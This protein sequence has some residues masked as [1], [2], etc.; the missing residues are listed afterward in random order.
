MLTLLGN[1]TEAAGVDRVDQARAWQKTVGNFAT[2]AIHLFFPHIPVTGCWIGESRYDFSPM[3][4]VIRNTLK[5]DPTASLIL[6]LRIDMP[7]WWI[8]GHPD[9][10]L[11][12]EDGT[13]SVKTSWGT[14]VKAPSLASALWRQDV[15][16]LLRS[17]VNHVGQ[18]DYAR[19]VVG[20][21]P[22]LFHGGEWFQEG[23]QYGKKADYS[24][25]MERAFRVWL[26]T[27][28]PDE[29]SPERVIPLAS[30]RDVGDIGHLRDPEKSRNVLDYYEFYHQ[31]IAEQ[32]IGYCRIFKEETAGR[33]ITG[34]YYGYS[35]VLSMLPGWLQRSGHLALKRVLESP[36]VD[37]IGSMLDNEYLEREGFGWSFG[38]LADSARLH[39]K[40]FVAEDEARTWLNRRYEQYLSYIPWSRTAEEEVNYLKRNFSC[41]MTHCEH[42]ELADLEGGWYDDQRIMDCVGRLA[43]I[44]GD[45]SWSRSPVTQIAL[46]IDETAYFYQ[47][48]AHDAAL[49][50]PLMIDSM[51]EYF[52]IGAPLDMYL[53]SDLTDGRVPLERYKLIVLLNPWHITDR[54]RDFIKT[55][56]QSDGRWILTYYAPGFIG[57]GTPACESIR[58]L[59]GIQVAMDAKPG[60]LQIKSKGKTYGTRNPVAPIFYA[61]DAHAE[62]LARQSN[63]D[64]PAVS[65]KRFDKWTSVYSAVPALPA[66]LLRRLAKDAGVH[67]YVETDD[68]I[69]ATDGFLAIHAG[70]AGAKDLRLP[71]ICNLYDPYDRRLDARR[72][73]GFSL[74]MKKGDT[75]LWMLGEMNCT[76]R[77]Q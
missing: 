7:D 48:E 16:H 47:D 51:P 71:K 42:E 59:I 31:Q 63:A 49:N 18:S 28:Y 73:Q 24:P 23:S 26:R 20:Y 41:A 3:D 37:Y 65:L 36:Y 64:R 43:R 58:D 4:T 2:E 11:L 29:A 77:Q 40:V 55:R 15:E 52:H 62:V 8:N 72:T 45:P 60:L 50:S 69:Y 14:Q 9:Q 76:K 21:H 68:L 67:L 54:Q 22:A 66:G 44:A 5:S 19:H 75:R 6:R 53:F 12:Y 25:L 1:P 30:Q 13:D 10:V 46:F 27:K 35:I 74:T 70:V 38:P 34:L 17:L 33:A 32:A 56:V 39:G 61:Q 57:R